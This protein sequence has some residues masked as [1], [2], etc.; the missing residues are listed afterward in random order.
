MSGLS[1]SRQ[2][3]PNGVT[4]IAKETRTTPAVTIYAGLHAGA[5]YDPPARGGLAHFVSRTLDRG[6]TTRS[7]DAIAEELDSRGVSLSVSINRHALWLV[8]NCL[9]EDFDA[10]LA[11]VADIVMRPAFPPAEVENRRGEIVTLIRQDDD[12]PAARAG[13]VLM[14]ALYSDAHPYGR[15]VRGT[16]ESVASIDRAALQQFHRERFVPGAM[17]LAL[18]GDIEPGRAIEA[19]AAE[20]GD[21]TGAP[22]LPFEAPPAPD[23]RARRVQIVPMMNK[24]Q[25]DI[26]Y[27][28]STI[29]RS[30]PRYYAYWL[31]N[32]ILGQYSLGGRLGDSIREKQGMAY[33]AMSTLE[34]NVV[35]GPLVI[36]A[37]VNP[38]NVERAVASID[39]ELAKMAAEGATERELKESKQYLI[40]SIPR[41]LETNLG[42]A[43]FLQ[44][45]EYFGLG[46]D[47]DVRL[48]GLLQAVTHDEVHAAARETLDP[49]RAA[50]A[51]AGPYDGA[52]A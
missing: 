42:I 9:V 26:A 18:V 12:N 10:V 1:P 37:G 39:T 34:A 30:D 33:Y 29:A 5:V 49:A 2:L 15:P 50:V 11:I 16:L 25:A 31:M 46:L 6:T 44:T 20:F 35:P 38:S 41:T 32:N 21:W 51:V 47:Y 52:L 17:S 7:A 14:R 23:G 3:L 36:R 4:V 40:G 27:G 22:R 48:P 43:T 8:C 13:E 28:F 19:A 45:A 24:A